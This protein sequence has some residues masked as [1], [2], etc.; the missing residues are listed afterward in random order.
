V[1]LEIRARIALE[2]AKFQA[3]A[4]V[5][6]GQ[7]K[8]MGTSAERFQNN[9][10]H[11][12]KRSLDRTKGLGVERVQDASKTGQAILAVEKKLA[13]DRYSVIMQAARRA[14]KDR[15]KLELE[16][17]RKGGTGEV[18]GS[19]RPRPQVNPLYAKERD[20]SKIITAQMR[21]D[22]E[23]TYNA[24]EKAALKAARAEAA[25]NAKRVAD[26]Q[27]VT[28][29]MRRQHEAA[30]RAAVKAHEQAARAAAK[31]GSD[32]QFLRMVGT[33]RSQNFETKLASTRYALYDVGNRFLAFGAAVEAS[34]FQSVKAF[35]DFETA[36][37]SVERTSGLTGNA[38]D[39]MRNKL[40]EISTTI[41]VAFA[42]VS[43]AATLGAQMG[44]AADSLD[45]FTNTVVKFASITGISVE[46]TAMSFGRLAQLMDVPVSKFENLSSAVAFTGVNSVAT[47]TEILRM[48]ESIAA[49]AT[50][51]GFAASE[52]IG[53]S[54]ALA[55]LKVRPEEARGVI[56]RLF[57][58]I[59]LSVSSGGKRLNDFAKVV[60]TTSTEA[61]NLWNQDPSQFVQAFLR[62][63]AATGQ[64]NQVITDLG[65]T[66]SRELNVITRLANNMDV[67]TTALSDSEEQF[68]LGTYATEAYGKVADDLNSKITIMQNS[69][70]A[71]QAKLGAGIGEALKPVID[72]ISSALKAIGSLPAP[73]LATATAITALVGGLIIFKGVM[74]LGI[75]GLFAMQ[76]AMRN[77]GVAAGGAAINFTTLKAAMF[78]VTGQANLASGA[79]QFF[80]LSMT[81]AA[82]AARVL[83]ISLGVFGAIALV[84]GTVASVMQMTEEAAKN[85]GK[86]MFD[87]AGGAE[88]LSAAIEK[89][90]AEA[91]A[92]GF[93]V[94][95]KSL[96]DLTD[97]EKEAREAALEAAVA[98]EKSKAQ[99]TESTKALEVA[100]KALADF[101]KETDAS[102]DAI[103]TNT[104][105][106]GENTQELILNAL[107]KY[108]EGEGNDFWAQLAQIRPETEAA[109]TELGFSAAGMVAAGLEKDGGAEDYAKKFAGALSI[110]SEVTED[111][112]PKQL[113]A[114]QA[115]LSRMGF[116]YTTDQIKA[117]AGAL[118]T[119]SA[120][121]FQE[122]G[123]LKGASKETDG[124]VQ[125]SVAA[126]KAS[127]IKAEAFNAAGLSADAEATE[128]E[129]LSDA[130][131]RYVSAATAVAN[132]GVYDSFANLAQAMKGIKGEI[133]VL[134]E[135]GR[136]ALNAW[137]SFMQA[138]IDNAVA[139]DTG[140][141]GSV[142]TM[143]AGI[144]A[145]G[146]EGINT[147]LQFQQMKQYIITSLAATHPALRTFAAT[148]TTAMDTD[149]LI[150]MIDAQLLVM[151][152]S[153]SM[154][155][156]MGKNGTANAAAF[157]SQLNQLKALRNSLKTSGT[158]ASNFA[159][160]YADALKDSEKSSEKA[161]TAVEKLLEKIASAFK[162]ANAF[163]SIRASLADLGSALL[164]NGNTFDTFSEKGRSNIAAVQGVIEQLAVRSGGNVNKFANDLASLRKALADAGVPA[165]GLNIIDGVLRR[166]GVSG[167]VSAISVAEFAKGIDSAA[168]ASE[169]A[170]T[171][172]QKLVDAMS[173]VFEATNIVVRL[174]SS[175]SD[176]GDS[177]REN[178]NSFDS[179]SKG[180]RS[181][182]GALQ[183]VI[184]ELATKSGGD[185][186][187]FANDL[188]S[189]RKALADAGVPASGLKIIDDVLKDI[190]KT[191]QSSA[192]D[193]RDFAKSMT[194]VAKE[195]VKAYRA[196]GDLSSKIRE[197]IA[198]SFAYRNSIDEI[199]LGWL[200]M[201]D[202]AKDAEDRIDSLKETIKEAGATIDS[203]TAKQSKLEFQL[204]I[205]LK[206][207]DTLR[208]AEIEAEL[209]ENA[210]KID[211][212]NR[213]IAKAQGELDAGVTTRQVIEQNRALEDMANRYADVAA[214][215]LITAP[216]GTDLNAIV[217]Q[218]T[219]AF[220]N[221]AIAMGY[222]E[223]EA[224][225]MADVL[226]NELTAAIKDIPEK[227]EP[228]VSVG[229]DDALS[230]LKSVMDG[231]AE[232]PESTTTT[233][234]AENAAALIAIAAVEA[235]LAEL[236]E[237]IVTKVEI[238]TKTAYDKVK[239]A[240]WLMNQ[241]L[242]EIRKP[243]IE[244]DT[245][246]AYN[247]VR[248]FV[249]LVNSQLDL[250]RNRVVTVTTVHQ[251]TGGSALGVVRRASGGLV[252][253]PGTATSDSIAARLS[254]G[255]YVIKAAAVQHYGV[256][257]M[258][259]L[260]NMALQSGNLGGPN[261][262]VAGSQTVYLSTED[263]NL[264]RAAIDRPIALYTD[265]TVIAQSANDGN[266]ILA[267]RGIR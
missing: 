119:N 103:E 71:L 169:R 233:V 224:R 256:D 139:N 159:S 172:L 153:V 149:A 69:F 60:G 9:V 164:D 137:S 29:A 21:K 135:D 67:L 76:L 115:T 31:Q 124:F 123:F 95:T 39:D 127:Q 201:E 223:K 109:L 79:M 2:V 23:A 155:A 206:Y 180:G 110:I 8:A 35:A 177:L 24:I 237:N 168:D 195:A 53:F 100:Q 99:V 228:T 117:M 125:Q 45:E 126:V 174:R 255:E 130:L 211:S 75:A 16:A 37:T 96:K 62:G 97:E 148:L 131:Q 116:D 163:I 102:S 234:V 202:A 246:T 12:A 210:A 4:K 190:G 144:Y 98:R 56:T 161:K 52:T 222:S 259:S 10:D 194:A 171:A 33:F 263:R 212:S 5:V 147:G 191:G 258:N 193:V 1:P 156:F 240:V 162:F 225:D 65:I 143:A 129:A 226:K 64:L 184:Q 245:T 14:D 248:S 25:A 165:A 36:F 84:L 249:S 19:I 20:S 146:Q 238:D 87:A 243:R 122:I 182:I 239:A 101:R 38:L 90:N 167:K 41:P 72:F 250:I 93:R 82:G 111:I 26:G 120:A 160:V 150:E 227:I 77:L 63:A 128:V 215:M 105:K 89:D 140:F 214:W 158:T 86:A 136:N 15:S 58:E 251:S 166:L 170:Q 187:K 207:G 74:A 241:R 121:L 28:D 11:Y 235:E 192:D 34:V 50:Q 151:Q 189:L 198:G 244:V 257:F 73:V 132:V 267:Q 61:A 199:T 68:V 231:I 18:T 176:L 30:A 78:A 108:G 7:F 242:A 178:G 188:A 22:W 32:A 17:I 209:K 42:D 213:E 197:G 94:V 181:N 6:A 3:N 47:D 13:D 236:P 91:S 262:S 48:S 46:Q 55:S 40:I 80:G 49:A 70:A 114:Y 196:V 247:R 85:T 205:A 88:A 230:R 133:D 54:S 186:Q 266:S 138:A 44:I 141:I 261:I 154:A 264:L 134:T 183:S 43:Q 229:V 260:N 107:S 113:E 217:K 173:G 252:T 221:A 265:N 81:K 27:R 157:T 152:S 112:S 175:L 216:A 92:E 219:D 253:G 200:D 83:Q 218:Q 51:A 104:T 142:E 66:N 179:F 57:R 59:D 254:N 220:Y 185:A 232:L 203:L 208:A 106:L 145:L 118:G 204:Q